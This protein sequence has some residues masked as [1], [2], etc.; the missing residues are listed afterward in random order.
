MYLLMYSNCWGKN[1][2]KII[3][4]MINSV[5]EIGEWPKHL[6]EFTM[7]ALKKEKKKKKRK[8]KPKAT[9][10]ATVTQSDSP[11]LQER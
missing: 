2:S 3:T 9:N 5:Y 1:G 10:T 4:E 6:I 7:M 11:H 8:R